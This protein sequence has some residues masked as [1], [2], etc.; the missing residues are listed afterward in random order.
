MRTPSNALEADHYA[1]VFAVLNLRDP[2]VRA[3]WLKRWGY[4]AKEL[5]LRGILLDSSFNLSSD[6]FHWCQNP[7]AGRAGATADETGLLGRFR[8][9]R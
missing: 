6:K 1:P 5:G 8:P 7:E 4:A 3:Y 9:E 2:A